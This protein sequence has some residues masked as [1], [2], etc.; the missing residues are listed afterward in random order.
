LPDLFRLIFSYRK[1]LLFSIIGLYGLFALIATTIDPLAMKLLVDDA[2][3]N[4][5]KDLFIAMILVVVVTGILI[6]VGMLWASLLTQKFQNSLTER[7]T[8]KLLATYTN[9][10]Y[11]NLVKHDQGYLMSRVYEEPKKI[12]Q[13]GTA[14]ILSLFEKSI[15]TLSALALALYFSWRVTLVL[16]V[17]VPVL[18]ALSKK[19][20][21]KITHQTKEE[22]ENEANLRGELALGLGAHK[23]ITNFDLA[24]TFIGSSSRTLN[25]Y[26]SSLYTRVKVSMVYSTT[27]GVF[28]ALT[29]SAV[30]VVAAIDVFLGN[31]T[32]GALLGFMAVFWKLMKAIMGLVADFPKYATISGY[33]QRMR[34]F[35]ALQS[36]PESID[37][38]SLDAKG[39]GFAHGQQQILEHLD[40]HLEPG[41]K[42]LI[43][44]PNGSCKSTLGY[45]LAGL[46]PASGKLQAPHPRRVSAMLAPLTFL[47]ATLEEHIFDNLDEDQRSYARFL[48]REFDLKDKLDKDPNSFSEGE[49]RKA[50]ITMTLLKDADLYIFDEPLTAVDTASK[51]IVMENIFRRA[52]GKMLV[53]ILHGDDE[54]HPQFD[55]FLNL[56]DHSAPSET[57]RI[58][59]IGRCFP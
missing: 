1:G 36:E 34:A 59:T 44:G 54:Y 43:Q 9:I 52:E 58:P 46:L 38:I 6:R 14:F 16:L 24:P 13:E 35:E 10:S 51:R 17:I 41:Q 42:L 22:S 56:G 32:I 2:L 4:K 12:A 26:L 25:T 50:Y 47:K 29:E 45:L 31:M 19:F 53:V 20:G 3:G 48:L 57:H 40:L 23:T 30:L 55:K 49:K 15:T 27:S 5:D 39:I 37:T 11:R 18:Y 7:L 21:A 33:L 8:Q 28:M